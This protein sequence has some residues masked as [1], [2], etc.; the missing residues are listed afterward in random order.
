MTV[1][2]WDNQSPES[3]GGKPV[4]PR[5]TVAIHSITLSRSFWNV[6]NLNVDILQSNLTGMTLDMRGTNE[7]N[8]RL[9]LPLIVFVNSTIKHF[10]GT[11][12]QLKMFDSLIAV[13]TQDIV[14]PMFV[15]KSS[16][17]DIYNCTFYGVGNMES[18]DSSEDILDNAVV[19]DIEYI[20]HF[21]I[22]GC[23][24]ENIQVDESY[25]VS[26][27]LYAENSQVE[28]SNSTFTKNKA[29]WAVI[30]GIR[31]NLNVSD[32]VFSN[33]KDYGGASIN[34]HQNSSLEVRDCTFTYNNATYGSGILAVIHTNVTV[35]NSEFSHNTGQQGACVNVQQNSSLAVHNSK[36]M[37]NN[38]TYGSGIQVL[39]QTSVY[40][41]DSVFSYNTGDQ[42]GSITVQQ[43]CN[44][45]VH[46]STFT[47]NKADYGAGIQT[48]FQTSVNITA[49]IFTNNHAIQGSGMLVAFTSTANIA[50]CIFNGNSAIK[51]GASVLVEQN[52]KLD[53]SN[54]IFKDNQAHFGGA[55]FVA[56]TSAAN[57]RSSLFKGNSAYQK[58]GAL[59]V[60]YNSSVSIS[61]STFTTNRA[62]IGGV[63]LAIDDVRLQIDTSTFIANNASSAGGVLATQTDVNVTLSQCI[64][65]KNIALQGGAVLLANSNTDVMLSKC[66]LTHN[67]APQ[68]A[69]FSLV[70]SYLSGSDTLF[71]NHSSKILHMKSSIL[72]LHFCHFFYNFL[73]QDAIIEAEEKSELVFDYTGFR[74]NNVVGI[75]HASMTPVSINSCRFIDNIV[76]G[77]GIIFA[78]AALLIMNNSVIHNNSVHGNPVIVYDKAVI[79]WCNFT[80]NTEKSAYG[81]IMSSVSGKPDLRLQVTQSTFLYNQGNV[82]TMYNSV[83]IVLDACKFTGNNAD[84]GTL[85]I[86]DDSATLRTSNTTFIAPKEGN[87]VALYFEVS[88][89]GTK[90]TDYLTYDTHFISGNNTLNSCSTDTF[91]QKAEAAG[92]VVIDKHVFPYMVTQEET[93]FASR[94]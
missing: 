14:Y 53:A 34:V 60:Q 46:N 89:K 35:F 15:M 86:R 9:S 12:V 55:L 13:N 79:S 61:N 57:I 11:S 90:M 48:V 83:D 69:V 63:I 59:N 78:T 31:S 43:N 65:S 84:K 2:V 40:V 24:F 47:D 67:T 18:Q 29:V 87:K 91:L 1:S 7:I 10:I 20:G 62:N 88:T 51:Y 93:A 3:S 4:W 85:Y 38:A 5:P 17:A 77:K 25:A 75:I 74:Y 70:N 23:V 36:F 19:F 54:S 92:L 32:S 66:N 72:K 6:I 41:K 39:N 81:L 22:R 82:I 94:K 73:T 76:N 27:A 56:S 68:W 26:G 80:N 50:S 16:S 45:E 37:H 44:L 42:G 30:M 58:G 21:A 52:S 33:N 8:N 71:F 64:A 49:S 28:I